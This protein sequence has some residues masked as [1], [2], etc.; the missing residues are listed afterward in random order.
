M[1]IMVYID[2]GTGSMLF[3]LALGVVSVLWF[4][5]KGIFMKLRYF[6][7][8]KGTRQERKSIVIY[9]EDKRYWT[10]FKSICDEFEKRKIPVT[11]LAGSKDDPI[12][13]EQYEFV[14]T[15]IIGLANKAYAKLSLMNAR[16]CLSTT[17]GLDVYQWKRS[18][19]VDFYV[20]LTHSLGGGTSYRMF[21]TQFYDAVLYCSDVFE[22]SHRE[23]EEL[24][25]SR[26]KELLAV[27]QTYMDSLLERKEQTGAYEH[28]GIN[29]L[30]APSWGENNIFHRYGEDFVQR[31]IDTGFDITIRPHPQSYISEPEQIEHLKARFPESSKLHW[32]NDSDNFEVLRRS[33]VM[34]SDYSGVIFDFSFIFEKPIIYTE[35]EP[36]WRKQDVA[37]LKEPKW[38]ASELLTQIGIELHTSELNDLPEIITGIVNCSEY[39]ASIRKA[40]DT[41]WQN[42][43]HAAETV[44]DYLIAKNEQLANAG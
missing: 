9:G 27:G 3:T 37:W 26:P 40:R 29:V 10:T 31:L 33:D 34:I 4:G 19:T 8:Q 44:V 1:S 42:R 43:G 38:W 39:K 15:E 12:L 24:R 21:G 13:S 14:E 2:P 22:A 17:P 25:G 20:H 35:T 32:N 5:L 11:Y 23:L 36:D 16:I 18:K 7:P 41:Y 6:T 30:L 28:E